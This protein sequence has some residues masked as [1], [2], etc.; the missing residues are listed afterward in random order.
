M[1]GI[2]FTVRLTITPIVAFAAYSM[3]ASQEGEDGSLLWA[4]TTKP[5]NKCRTP[6]RH[7]EQMLPVKVPQFPRLL[8]SS[9]MD[10]RKPS[11]RPPS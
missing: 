1:T 3:T 5:C 10:P 8:L 7:E 11:P 9:A 2:C 4:R 6:K